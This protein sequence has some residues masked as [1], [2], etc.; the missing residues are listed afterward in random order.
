MKKHL[1][2]PVSALLI[3]LAAFAAGPKIQSGIDATS[4]R[5]RANGKP[6]R[7]WANPISRMN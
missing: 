2:Y 6:I 3:A 7:A 1:L 4:E 5:W